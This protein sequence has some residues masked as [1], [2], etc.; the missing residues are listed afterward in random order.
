MSIDLS[1]LVC[2]VHTRYDTFLP[3]IQKQLYEQYENLSEPDK[4]RV[5]II[6][7]T[8]NKKMM[9]GHK[10]NVMVDIAQGKYIQFT[11]DDDRVSDDFISTLLEGIKTDAD[12]IVFQ[13]EVSL[14]GGGR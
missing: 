5:E 11:D 8:D 2:S 12:C 1:I 14:H 9:L 4:G 10:R 6:V 13:A 3:K 7:V